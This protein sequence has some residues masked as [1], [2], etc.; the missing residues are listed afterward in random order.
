VFLSA[1]D[2]KE[3]PGEKRRKMEQG[4][5]NV[6]RE[7]AVALVGHEHLQPETVNIAL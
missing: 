4:L 5:H 3:W 7:R 2:D 1:E 6:I